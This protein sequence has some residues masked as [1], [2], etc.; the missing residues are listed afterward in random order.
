MIVH[1]PHSTFSLTMQPAGVCFVE[2]FCRF[3][4]SYLSVHFVRVF[5]TVQWLDIVV[6]VSNELT[7]LVVVKKYYL[8]QHSAQQAFTSVCHDVDGFIC[9]LRGILWFYSTLHSCYTCVDDS[10]ACCMCV[11]F[12]VLI[13]S[14]NTRC[15]HSFYLYVW[16][17]YSKLTMCAHCVVQQCPAKRRLR[18]VPA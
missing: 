3:F 18:V 16:L 8:A 6:G 15:Y 2:L 5:A 13:Y 9:V 7:L 4:V 14:S 1:F 12:F 11:C 10:L 17:F